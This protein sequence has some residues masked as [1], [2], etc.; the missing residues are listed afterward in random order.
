MCFCNTYFRPERQASGLVNIL[1][2]DWHINLSSVGRVSALR[3][4]QYFLALVT[5]QSCYFRLLSFRQVQFRMDPTLIPSS[6]RRDSSVPVVP[7]FETDLSASKVTL[8]GSWENENEW[9]N[10]KQTQIK[11]TLN[12]I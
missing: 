10:F 4:K 7:K 11:I 1:V 12:L 8:E 6:H 2:R 5:E 9:E 3:A